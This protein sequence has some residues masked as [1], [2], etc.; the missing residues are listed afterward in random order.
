[1]RES[2]ICRPNVA[3]TPIV[4]AL[5]VIAK[6]GNAVV[7]D[8]KITVANVVAANV[9][10]AIC[11]AL[12]GTGR[13]ALDGNQP[14]AGWPPAFGASRQIN[15]R[16]RVVKHIQRRDFVATSLGQPLQPANAE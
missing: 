10:L 2:K 11:G 3:G 12:G 4:V 14:R 6:I 1:M 16:G 8:A 5:V 7:A 15:G 13:K 9:T